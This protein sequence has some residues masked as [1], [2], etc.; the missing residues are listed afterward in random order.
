MKI[1]WVIE[2]KGAG[3]ADVADTDQAAKALSA[4]VSALYASDGPGVQV[5]VLTALVAPLR[6][7][8]VTD[9]RYA[10]ERGREWSANSAPILVTLSPT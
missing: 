2:G 9:G 3:S 5:H 6:A 1:T 8:L 10:V 4:A 7:S